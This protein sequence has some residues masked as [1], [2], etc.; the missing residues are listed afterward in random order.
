MPD[1]EIFFAE[2][3]IFYL[4]LVAAFGSALI[5]GQLILRFLGLDDD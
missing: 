1:I 5:I 4:G 2:Q 3:A